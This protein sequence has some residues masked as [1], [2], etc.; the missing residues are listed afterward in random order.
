MKREADLAGS[1][2]RIAAEAASALPAA[3]SGG[4]LWLRPLALVG[5]I[6]LF[7]TMTVTCV[8]V[9]GRY[10]LN[11]PLPGGFELTEV[12]MAALIFLGMP[13]VT[14]KDEHIKVDILDVFVSARMR[15]LQVAFG[16]AVS[17]GVSA[18]L[19]W[20]LWNKAGQVASYADRTEVLHIPLTPVAYLMFAMMVL[21]AAIFWVQLVR[22][23]RR[24]S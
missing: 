21:V 7:G 20:T 5:C 10:F 17:G 24:Q 3:R 23:L 19:A 9:V 1:E 16:C 2:G 4:D 11:A 8:D 12:M 15:R 14:A 18:L 6:L 22:A 13:L